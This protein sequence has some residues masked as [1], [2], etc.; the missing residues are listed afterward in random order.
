MLVQTGSRCYTAFFIRIDPVDRI[1]LNK[2][3]YIPACIDVLDDII[4]NI[5]PRTFPSGQSVEFLKTKT[6]LDI[7][8]D[9]LTAAQR[10]HVTKVYYE[11]PDRFSILNISACK[12]LN[13]GEGLAVDTPAD[14]DRLEAMRAKPRFGDFLPTNNEAPHA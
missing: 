1:I 3:I 8:P 11:T 9:N 7:D 13:L 10:E 2:L 12:P 5:F 4:T 14:L 6:F